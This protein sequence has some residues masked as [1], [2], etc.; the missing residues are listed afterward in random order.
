MFAI[1]ISILKICRQN[2]CLFKSADISHTQLIQFFSARNPYPPYVVPF[3]IAGV[4]SRRAVSPPGLLL[5]HQFFALLSS[6]L[7]DGVAWIIDLERVFVLHV[8]I[9][10]LSGL[11]IKLQNMG[12]PKSQ[13]E[14]EFSSKEQQSTAHEPLNHQNQSYKCWEFPSGTDRVRADF[15]LGWVHKQSVFKASLKK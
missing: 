11:F 4:I 13:G 6:P 14:T 8:G 12:H 9:F 15:R 10:Y 2:E 5:F 7:V 3:L 1:I